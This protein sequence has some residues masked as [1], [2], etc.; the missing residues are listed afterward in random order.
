[1]GKK[2]KD[3]DKNDDDRSREE[4]SSQKASKD[5]KSKSKIKR[6][7]SNGDEGSVYSKNS[8]TS[9][10]PKPLK[11]KKKKRKDKTDGGESDSGMMSDGETA[12]LADDSRDGRSVSSE[13]VFVKRKRRTG[14]K[15]PLRAASSSGDEIERMT[16]TLRNERPRRNKSSAASSASLASVASASSA[17]ISLSAR[18]DQGRSRSRTTGGTSN[19]DA[20]SPSMAYKSPTKDRN[21]SRSSRRKSMEDIAVPTMS[22]KGAELMDD[23]DNLFPAPSSSKPSPRPRRGSHSSINSMPSHDE[24]EEG[25]DEV[26]NSEGSADLEMHAA[27]QRGMSTAGSNYRHNAND[28]SSIDQYQNNFAFHLSPTPSIGRPPIP[29]S[30]I[31]EIQKIQEVSY[32]ESGSWKKRAEDSVIT[33]ESGRRDGDNETIHSLSETVASLNRQLDLQR[34]ETVAL[35]KQL[36]EALMKV[37]SLSENLRREETAAR[38]TN[39]YL[40]EAKNDLNNIIDEK[41]ELADR[42]SAMQD[43]LRAKDERIEKLQQVVETQ[44]DTLEFL[45]DK[46]EKTEDELFAMEG[47]LKSFED[48]GLLDKSVH[49]TPTFQDRAVKMDSI[50]TGRVTRKESLSMERQKSRRLLVEETEPIK[51]PSAESPDLLEREKKIESREKELLVQRQDLDRREVRLEEW[52]KELMDMDEQ[53][54]LG[55]G[56][57]G[58]IVTNKEKLLERRERRL[59]ESRAQ[60]QREKAAWSERLLAL[61][62]EKLDVSNGMSML[63]KEQQVKALKV[64]IENLEREKAALLERI[65]RED[66]LYDYPKQLHKLES[67]N[68]DLQQKLED[69]KSLPSKKEK[70]LREQVT[71]MEDEIRR[72]RKKSKNAVDPEKYMQHMQDEI[73]EQLNE[74]DDENQKLNDKLIAE[75]ERFEAEIKAKEQVIVDLEE[76]LDAL[77][78]NVSSGTDSTD[79]VSRLLEEISALKRSNRELT[80]VRSELDKALASLEKKGA[81]IEDLEKKLSQADR[82]ETSRQNR[83]DEDDGKDLLIRELQNQLVAAKKKAHELGSGD[84]MTRLKLEVKKLKEGYNGLR[85]RLK[86]EERNHST[87]LQEKD[88]TIDSMQAK[89]SKLQLALDRFERRQKNLGA[90]SDNI[91]ESALQRHIEDLENEIDHWKTTNAD[92]ENELNVVKTEASEW[93]AKAENTTASDDDDDC[94]LGS[95]H[96]NVSNM[97]DKFGGSSHSLGSLTPDDLFFVS[98]SASVRNQRS[99]MSMIALPPGPPGEEEPST[100]SQRALRSVSNLW[101]KI[102]NGP[103]DRDG[104]SAAQINPSIPYATRPLDDDDD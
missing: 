32:A 22:E 56:L 88:E 75:T 62:R 93:K 78:R 100:P 7:G 30:P 15:K 70:I 103:I 53:V 34:D 85:E 69:A 84:Y 2:P 64:A 39:S 55:D 79:Q 5:K 66:R 18:V 102:T 92:L 11:S 37:A 21:R 44:L 4:T 36:T 26:D 71:S 45:E 24:E 3:D 29:R 61:E 41:A 38:K 91:T 58:D 50:R 63:E 14:K 77:K 19:I 59:E 10:E 31:G 72:L 9:I 46:L 97:K 65:Q 25:D 23:L 95:V 86:Q 48:E 68:K 60:L 49:T 27:I 1:M 74:L 99:S 76:S 33:V 13:G 17:S 6:S 51:R 82:T 43:D 54:K 40:Q 73:A 47:E 8:K 89:I 98:D 57:P 90:N 87:V 28:R 101:S 81:L 35:Q 80:D 96:S 20:S 67:E 104:P 42:I 12:S 52:E 94:S 83:D 16:S